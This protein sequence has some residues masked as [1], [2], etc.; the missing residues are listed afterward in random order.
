MYFQ[1]RSSEPVPE[2]NTMIWS[3]AQEGCKGW[4]RDNFSFECAPTC[5]Q[6]HS[7]MV[8]SV[9]MLPL[10]SNPNIDMKSLKKGVQI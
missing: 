6:C 3:C 9:K 4:M 2:E 1:K 5:R 8:S 10:L 7:P